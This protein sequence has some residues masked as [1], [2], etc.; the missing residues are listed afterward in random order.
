[1][2]YWLPPLIILIVVV[3]ITVILLIKYFQGDVLN[4]PNSWYWDKMRILSSNYTASDTNPVYYFQ[5][6][7]P[8]SKE[9][10]T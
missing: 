2:E 6:V 8:R 10:P 4:L 1:V 3:I 9:E 7:K 5:E